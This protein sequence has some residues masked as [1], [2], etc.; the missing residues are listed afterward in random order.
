[1]DVSDND[2]VY[3]DLAREI[4]KMP[5]GMPLTESGKEIRILKHLFTPEE[6]RIALNLNV[7]PETLKRIHG[8]AKRNGIDIDID[9]LERVLD[10]LE[11]KGAIMT[12]YENNVK[13]Y[14]YS[15]F[16]LGMYEF[17]VDR[18]TPEFYKDCESYI[19]NE[20]GNEYHSLKYP[21]TRVV[22]VGKSIDPGMHVTT[23]DSLR[24]IFKSKEGRFAVL[25]C[26]CKQGKDMAGKSCS[27]TDVRETCI[28]LP[29]AAE[30]FLGFGTGRA[31]Y[32]DEAIEILERAEKEGL[33]L[34]PTNSE[35]PIAVCCCCG[36]CCGILASA[37]KFPRPAELFISNYTAYVD[38]GMCDPGKCADIKNCVKR[39]QMDA[40]E[41]SGTS[42][43][44][45]LERCIGC[46]LCVNA[47]PVNA[48]KLVI[49]KKTQKPPKTSMDYY[50]LLMLKKLGV[51][52]L[53]KTGLKLLFGMKI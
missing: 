9:E 17:Q 21:Q 37:K 48:L 52:R 2:R 11:F 6:A 25:N 5:V 23:Y 27:V 31:I 3:Y 19:L 34:Q 49:K 28:M 45:D 24:E 10:R 40:I 50:Y 15:L 41:I 29:G 51:F 43:R 22:P 42:A 4:D 12:Y 47:C 44:V 16:A 39:C 53:I 30:R 38:P 13:T 33:V 36:D 8:R 20:F 35:E 7:M 46:G 26:L 1:M 14:G 18:L 32:C